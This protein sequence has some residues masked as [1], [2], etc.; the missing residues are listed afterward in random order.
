MAIEDDPYWVA[1]MSLSSSD[2]AA[3]R[4]EA[5]RSAREVYD[6]A[7]RAMAA[8]GDGIGHAWSEADATVDKFKSGFHGEL[9]KLLSSASAV[10]AEMGGQVTRGSAPR[11]G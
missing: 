10:G 2:L 11:T 5:E 9:D 7:T 4:D 6:K 8:A 1:R 3:M